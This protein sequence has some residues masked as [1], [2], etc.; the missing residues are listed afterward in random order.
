VLEDG[1][2]VGDAFVE[3]EDVPIGGGIEEVTQTVDDGVRCLV[4]DDVV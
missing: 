1:D 3:C 2:D 4:G